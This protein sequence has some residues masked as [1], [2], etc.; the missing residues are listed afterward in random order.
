MEIFLK[1]FF[2]ILSQ[3]VVQRYKTSFNL[4]QNSNSA[5][6]PCG[7]F[8][9]NSS[10]DTKISCWNV[11][12]ADQITSASILLNYLH[13]ARDM[14]FHPYDNLIAFC[15]YDTNAPIYVFKY[16]SEKAAKDLKIHKNVSYLD[17]PTKTLRADGTLLHTVQTEKTL[18][19]K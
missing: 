8:L 7:T 15:C 2:I 12:T 9:F 14:D 13:P 6:T 1:F 17:E 10:A 5:M 11:D 3:N 18:K 4:N 19:E 16:D